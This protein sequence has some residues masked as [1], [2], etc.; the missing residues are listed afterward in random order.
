MNV[1]RAPAAIGIHQIG[2]RP[3]ALGSIALIGGCR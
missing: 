1:G 3:L 2:P